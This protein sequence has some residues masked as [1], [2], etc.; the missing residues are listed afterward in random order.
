MPGGAQGL[1]L[2]WF[3]DQESHIFETHMSCQGLNLGQPCAIL[4]YH[5]D[6]NLGLI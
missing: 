2:V 4:Y 6:P 3:L 5:S 1:L